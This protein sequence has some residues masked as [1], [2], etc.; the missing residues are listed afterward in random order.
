MHESSLT[1]RVLRCTLLC[2]IAW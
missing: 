2:H 1:F